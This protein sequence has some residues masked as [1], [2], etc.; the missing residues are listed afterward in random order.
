MRISDWSSDV[1]SSDLLVIS[2]TNLLAK[3]I[4]NFAHLHRRRVTFM[5]G[6]VYQTTPAMLRDLPA[7][8]EEQVKAAGQEFIRSSFVTFGPSSLDFELLFDVFSDDYDVVTAART[9]VAIRLLE[10]MTN[11]GY[12]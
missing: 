6:V 5:L 12:D 8:L 9:D 10:A 1:C 11:A 2:N 4:T 7:L 3:E